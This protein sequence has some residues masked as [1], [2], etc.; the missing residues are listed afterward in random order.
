VNEHLPYDPNVIDRR[1]SMS[2]RVRMAT[3]GTVD[4]LEVIQTFDDDSRL[5]AAEAARHWF[6]EHGQ[7]ELN[8]V[9]H[10]Q[11]QNER[12]RSERTFFVTAVLDGRHG[13]EA[14]KVAERILNGCQWTDERLAR[15]LTAVNAVRQANPTLPGMEF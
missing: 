13:P 5:T 15:V 4:E 1:N 14:R 9:K 2:N 11:Q 10:V 7:S 3:S 8:R 12:L 6:I